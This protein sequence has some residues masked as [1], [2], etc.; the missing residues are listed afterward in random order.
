MGG[1]RSFLL[2]AKSREQLQTFS[3]HQK[4]IFCH[5]LSPDGT[6]LATG[7]PDGTVKLWDVTTGQETMSLPVTDP[8]AITFNQDG[9]RLLVG[10]HNGE[11]RAYD[12]PP[13][14]QEQD[15]L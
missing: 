6:R 10:L 1:T 2:D 4:S 8:E 12:A 7:S 11:V 15:P 14:G 13:D 3:G 5:A 9:S